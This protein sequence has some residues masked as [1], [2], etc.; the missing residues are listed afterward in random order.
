[1]DL[2]SLYK[3]YIILV[4]KL[5][6]TSKGKT[7]TKRK[8]LRRK[9]NQAAQAKEDGLTRLEWLNKQGKAENSRVGNDTAN[10]VAKLVWGK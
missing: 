4:M 7:M 5:A 3:Q 9:M 8:V 10:W 2:T 1:M 6:E